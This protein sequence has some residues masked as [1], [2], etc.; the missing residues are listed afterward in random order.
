MT[1]LENKPEKLTLRKTGSDI[2]EQSLERRPDR[3]SRREAALLSRA[4]I[5][6]E[7]DPP[8]SLKSTVW[9]ICIFVLVFVGW[10]SIAQFDEKAVAPG[11]ILPQTLVQPVQHLEGGI[12]SK[13]LVQEGQFVR[14]GDP[15]VQMDDT[16]VKNER[17]TAATRHATFRLQMELWK[18]Y[19]DDREPDFSEYATTYPAMAEDALRAY[20]ST[21]AERDGR[22]STLEAQISARKAEL[23]GLADRETSLLNTLSSLKE[24]VAVKEKLVEAGTLPRLPFMSL[25]RELTEREGDVAQVRTDIGRAQANLFEAEGRKKE[26]ESEMRRVALDELRRV[27]TE[28]SSRGDQLATLNDRLER[29]IVRAPVSGSIKGLTITK[30]GAVIPSGAVILEVVPRN[31]VL[32]AEVRVSPADVGHIK[33]G[34]PAIIKVDTYKYGRLGGIKGTVSRISATTFRDDEGLAFFKTW[35]V[36]ELDYVGPDPNSN[37]VAPGMT[38]VADIKT[39]SK[40]LM[41]YLLRPITY[42]LDAAFSER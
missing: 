36:L 8:Q 26:L 17:N 9:G 4:V 21:I 7:T 2:T 28:A 20:Q 22:I 16:L 18:A 12:V 25:Q 6:E 30:P 29:T 35:I 32:I 31:E 27:T 14:A 15:L 5:L 11:E 37:K 13:I 24:E 40:S 41:A 19:L 42:S 1:D 34:L 39:G 23:R 33:E 3:L 10:A 38:L